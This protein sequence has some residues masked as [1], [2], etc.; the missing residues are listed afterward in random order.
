M[1]QL[2]QVA[3]MPEDLARKLFKHRLDFLSSDQLVAERKDRNYT[4]TRV[5]RSLLNLMLGITKTDSVRFKEYGSA[6]W[7][8]ILG[9]RKDVAPL[10]SELK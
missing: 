3:G 10:L 7:L 9:F 6:P 5:N 8:R 4:Y 2:L 1:D